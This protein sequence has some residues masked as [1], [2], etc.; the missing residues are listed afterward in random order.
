[1]RAG[2]SRGTR[3]RPDPP[4][5]A[6]TSTRV[7]PPPRTAHSRP[8]VRIREPPAGLFRS[9]DGRRCESPGPSRLTIVLRTP[10]WLQMCPVIVPRLGRLANERLPDLLERAFWHHV[11]DLWLGGLWPHGFSLRPKAVAAPQAS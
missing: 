2:P 11:R 1:H 5:S 3:R 8:S 10:C 6:M 9:A 7:I 4:R